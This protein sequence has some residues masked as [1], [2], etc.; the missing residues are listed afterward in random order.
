M[1]TAVDLAQEQILDVRP[2]EVR[3]DGEV[4]ASLSK[5]GSP[6]CCRVC[7]CTGVRAHVH[8]HLFTTQKCFLKKKLRCLDYGGF[9]NTEKAG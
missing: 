3:E 5:R 9:L 4:V 1:C 7:A 8:T 2:E 6:C